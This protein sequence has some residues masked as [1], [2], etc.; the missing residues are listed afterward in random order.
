MS[1]V[2]LT[3]NML[4]LPSFI[5]SGYVWRLSDKHYMLSLPSFIPSGYVRRLSDK[6]YMLGLP[7][8]IPSGYIWRLSDQSPCHVFWLFRR[9]SVLFWMLY[10]FLMSNRCKINQC[11]LE[12]EVELS[13]ILQNPWISVHLQCLTSTD[14]LAMS[15]T[16]HFLSSWNMQWM[17]LLCCI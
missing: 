1:G 4:G 5:P 14:V 17:L 6:H 9:E 8:C 13:F 7:S 12:L 15:R 11:E 10:V 3:R 2:C 16:A